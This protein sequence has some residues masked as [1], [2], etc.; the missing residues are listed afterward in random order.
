MNSLIDELP[1][2]MVRGKKV[3]EKVLENISTAN[4]ITLQTNEL[5]IPT[6]AKGGLTEFFGQSVKKSD[7]TDW[8]NRL[9]YGDNLLVIEA[10]LTGDPKTKLPSMRGMIDLIY[11]DPPFDSKAD[12]RADIHLPHDDI[13]HKP[14]ILEQFAYSDMWKN[15]TA[16]YLEM[17]IPRL[18]LMRE[19]LSEQGSIY[20]HTDW[21]VGHY[22]KVVM[23]EIFGK[24]NLKNE[25]TWKRS[26]IAT[27]ASIQFRNSHDLL[28]FYGKSNKSIFNIQY[29]EYSESSKQHY[30][31]KDENGIFR[32][33]PLMAS[34]KTSSGVSGQ[35]WRGVDVATRGKSGMHWLKNPQ[36]LEKLD[37][38]GKIYWNSEGIPE[39]KYYTHEA[40]G[41]YISDVWDDID[42]I[43]SNAKESVGYDTQKP[44]KL[45]TRIIQASSSEDSIVAD[46]FGGSGTTG[47][48]A[49]KLGRK[50]IMSDIGKP[51][52]MIMRKRLVDQ[53]TKP[54]LYHSI[55]DYQKEQFEQSSYRTIGDLSQVVV[56]LY[57]ALPFPDQEG[58]PKNLGYIKQSKTLV[59]VDS[60]TKLTGYNSL[61][62]AQQLRASFMGGWNKVVI[63]GWN[64]SPDIA[65]IVESLNDKNLQ[66]LVIPPDLLDKLKTKASYESLIK[67]GKIKFSSLQ[68]LTIKPIKI[69][70][71][72]SGEDV[73]NIEL[74][75]YILLS[76]DALPLD[77]KNKDKLEK[78]IEK[79]PISLIEYWS[80]DPNY[81]GETFRSKWQEYRENNKDL[82]IKKTA[83]LV[84]P[85][86][87]GKRTIC[88]KAVDVFSFESAT[89]HVI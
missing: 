65:R 69:V 26:A 36:A 89:V 39:L 73:L 43:N 22:V 72:E 16:S 47:V 1:K 57:G 55:G 42:V 7:K 60:P 68:Y 70:K 50:W 66:V 8:V 37:S 49:E 17:I 62:K 4:R 61:K 84:V 10:L 11:I 28:L 9:I 48:V 30:N 64:F 88:V 59:F 5:V 40:K 38:E 56:N 14:R 78:I 44:E 86:I 24:H 12:Y 19:L 82:R 15:G 53:E 32:T 79:D 3:A 13:Q 2:I 35:A 41:V 46:F 74:D 25:I 33:V 23:D 58:T 71:N 83:K 76:P 45:L 85:K 77:E 21:H 29:G 51:S 20:V 18:I 34:G 52:F 31:K 54:F 67:S 80:I 6:K 81:D 63:L 87:K 27:N 75:N